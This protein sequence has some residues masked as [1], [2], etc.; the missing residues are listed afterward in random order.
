MANR[1]A[2]LVVEDSEADA[3]VM[4][5]ELRTGGFDPRHERVED[6]LGLDGAI[7]KAPWDIVLLDY[8]M[9][10]MSAERA[11]IRLRE[12]IPDVPVIVV[13]AFVGEEAVVGL[14]KAGAADYVPKDKLRRLCPA[15]E[16]ALSEAAVRRNMARAE[17]T[18]RKLLREMQTILD[19]L[20][21]IAFR[22]DRSSR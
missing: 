18:N 4:L 6:A 20:P 12:R 19:N 7:G 8:N 9:P 14:M 17:E 3:G 5:G 11:L 16:R 1:I 2:V 13:S 15:V 22:K 21:A 10:R